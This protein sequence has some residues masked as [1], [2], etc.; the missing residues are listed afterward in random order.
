MWRQFNGP[1][2]TAVCNAIFEYFQDTYDKTLEYLGKFK[3]STANESHLTFL[4]IL[5]GYAR[6]LIP[7]PDEQ[8]FWWGEEFG[9]IDDPDQPGHLIPDSQY[10]V[11]HGFNE[12][13]LVDGA[14]SSMSLVGGKLDEVSANDEGYSYLP[15]YIFRAFLQ[16]NAISQ[17]ANAS[18]VTLDNQLN[19]VWKIEHDVTAPVYR[20][21]FIEASNP[22]YT[23]GDIFVDLGVTGDW[24]YP[25]E[26]QAEIKLLG[27]TLF[28]P[29]PRII[30][31]LR[32]GDSTIDPYGFI[33]ILINTDEDTYGLDA[34]WAGEG[35]PSDYIANGEDPD[36]AVSP[37]T[38]PE[39]QM[40]WSRDNTWQDEEAPTLELQAL[41]VDEITDMWT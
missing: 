1:Q 37:I 27:S 10:P 11:E 15:G 9:Y 18:L 34:M 38:E 24:A 5:A 39:L 14:S 21:N 32:E 6:P 25:Y 20:F 17:G 19:E 29:I 36:F 7:I 8:M 35:T 12:S 23:V 13:E 2:I 31:Q 33:R 41:S 3:I 4:G 22:R 28:Y 26:T 30:P 40:M 16:G